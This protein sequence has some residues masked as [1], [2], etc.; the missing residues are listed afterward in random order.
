VDESA[1]QIATAYSVGRRVQWCRNA[2]DAAESVGFHRGSNSETA[3]RRTFADA[4]PTPV[5]LNTAFNSG[6]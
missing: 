4:E 1:E 3:R 2:A 5:Y 6:S